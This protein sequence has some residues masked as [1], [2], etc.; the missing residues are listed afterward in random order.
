[1]CQRV[2]CRL[3]LE[4]ESVWD[5]RVYAVVAFCVVGSG[6]IVGGLVTKCG[7]MLIWGSMNEHNS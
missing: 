5:G 3:E 7:W 4:E 2:F 6:W 1:M